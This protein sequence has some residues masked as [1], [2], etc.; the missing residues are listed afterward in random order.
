MDGNPAHFVDSRNFARIARA[1]A[2]VDSHYREQPRLAALARAAGL[3]PFHFNR[4]FRR[5]AGVTPKQYLACVTGRAAALAL[6]A[7]TPVLEAAYSVGLS[8]SGRLHDL[9]VTLEGVTPGEL[10]ARGAGVQI[11]WGLSAT[12]FGTALLGA[13]PRGLCYLAFVDRPRVDADAADLRAAWPRATLVRDDTYARELARRV[14]NGSAANETL[15]LAARGTNFQLKVWR[16]LLDLDANEATTYGRIAAGLGRPDSSR[17]VG[18]A[19]GANPIAWL[20]PCHRVLRAG[21]ALG[22]YHWGVERKR[23]M[24]AFESVRASRAS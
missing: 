2:F 9:T 22:G 16:A 1:I 5:W 15:Q 8:G 19:V 11:R 7:E 12:P 24:L 21:G 4:L 18:N 20:I 6:R 23:A 13:A 14:W 10:R 3:S 17:A